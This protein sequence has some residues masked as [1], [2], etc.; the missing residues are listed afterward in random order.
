MTKHLLKFNFSTNKCILY[1]LRFDFTDHHRDHQR[2][3]KI[4]WWEITLK[5]PQFIFLNDEL[6][7]YEIKL[8]FRIS[9][10]VISDTTLKQASK[11]TINNSTQ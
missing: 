1:K 8:T 7:H 5:F 6:I 4:N 3:T 10:L 2:L 9:S 11:Q